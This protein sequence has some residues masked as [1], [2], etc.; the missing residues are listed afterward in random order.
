MGITIETRVI[1]NAGVRELYICLTPTTAASTAEQIKELFI[2][3]A[4]TLK[5]HNAWI[6]QERI[7]CTASL[8]K[9]LV[10]IRKEIYGPLCDGVPPAWLE[11]SPGAYGRIGGILIHAVCGIERP[12]PITMDSCGCGRIVS[13]GEK[14]YIGLSNISVPEAGSPAEQAQAMLEKG[15]ALLKKVG[16]DFNSVPRTW[17]WLKD[18]LDWYD[19]FNRVRTQF[20]T[21]HGIMGSGSS[22]YMPASTGIGIGPADKGQS[23]M[24]LVAVVGSDSSI[25]YLDAG[26]NQQSAFDYG[27]AFSRATIA[28]SPAGKTLYIS[29]TAAIDASGATVFIEDAEGQIRDTIKNVEAILKENHCLDDDVVQVIAYCKT[30]EIETVFNTIRHELPWPWMTAV[31]DICRDDLLFEIEAAARINK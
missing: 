4:E 22:R 21:K 13:L 5:S 20:F 6:F 1:E 25:Q 19:D 15:E 31:T 18:V 8:T 16:T 26:G 27:S 30:P 7:F 14:K 23:C 24:D 11:I 10:P 3:A 28:S 9:T 29:G 12:T 2:K 17:M